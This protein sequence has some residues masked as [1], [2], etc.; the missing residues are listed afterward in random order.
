MVRYVRMFWVFA[1][2]VPLLVGCGGGD[3]VA[4]T[5]GTGD[6]GATVAPTM[7][8]QPTAMAVAPTAMSGQPVAGATAGASGDVT[9]IAVEDGAVVRF[10]AAGNPTEQKLYQEGA[11]RFS[12]LFPGVKVTFE[13]IQ[14]YQTSMKAA[15][16]GE[17]AP[18]VFLLDG[19]LMGQFAPEGLLL[20][21][22]EAMQTAGVQASD[23]YDALIQ[24]YQLDGKTFGIPKDFNPLV[25]FVNTEMAQQAGVDPTA[26]KTWDDWKAAAAKMTHGEGPSKTY[27]LCLNQDILRVGAQMFQNGNAVID[28][29]KAVFDQP[30]GVDAVNFWYSF[31]KDGSGVLFKDIG[32]NWCGEAFAGKNTA[33]AVEG[34]WLVPFLANPDNGAAGM[35]YTAIALPV[36]QGGQQATW[37]FT[38]GFAVN[39]KTK[40]P[41]AAAAVALFLTSAM[42]EQALIPS[43]LASP[44]LQVLRGDAFFMSDPVQQVLVQQGAYGRLADTLLG[45]PVKK[46]D[47]LKLLN[48]GMDRVFLSDESAKD[49]LAEVATGV[50]AIL[51]QP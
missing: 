37:L 4:P 34:G 50:N 47:V 19:E 38:N 22:D 46:G 36:P 8:A 16:A 30:S 31:K 44:S 17:T 5:V 41:K 25:L 51:A 23:Y 39:A 18:D 1:L 27:G 12:A 15:M 35:K 14:D 21:L 48:D 43:G 29:Q 40:Y 26:I 45:G 2:L 32:K 10:G 9:K 20:P 6:A 3:A 24:L 28:Q 33:M 13:P 7:S 11:E 49:V 42:N